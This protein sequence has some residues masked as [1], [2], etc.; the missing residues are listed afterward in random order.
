MA[1]DKNSA[2]DT[3]RPDHEGNHLAEAAARAP[4]TTPRVLAFERFDSAQTMVDDMS[5]TEGTFYGH[6]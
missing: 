5:P 2:D 3:A 6:S 1:N 4:W